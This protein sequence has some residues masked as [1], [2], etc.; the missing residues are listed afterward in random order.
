VTDA[1]LLLGYLDPN[2]FL[3]GSMALD[4]AAA[5]TAVGGLGA[6]LGLSPIETAWAV[7]Q[8]VNESMAGAARVHVIEKAQDPRR[9]ALL[10]FGGGGPVH[11]AGVA[12]A[13]GIGQVLCPPGAGVASAI[14]LLVAPPS[15]E[16]ARSYPVRLDQIDWRALA[17]LYRELEAQAIERLAQVGVARNEITFERA[18]DGRIAGQLHEIGIPLSAD[19]LGDHR[20]GAVEQLVE[21][22]NRRYRELYKHLPS[23]RPIEL[24]S[25]RLT[26]RGPRPPVGLARS[27]NG[28]A[29]HGDVRKGSRPAYFL[30]AF[31]ETAVYARYALVPGIEIAGPAIVEER[32]STTVVPPDMRATVDPFLNLVITPT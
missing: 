20:G 28:P 2:Y 29:S 30:N 8:V 26:A 19:L 22:F 27:A 18:I 1:D 16:L 12:R 15:L 11:A 3:G 17:D 21:T 10:A 13:L 31:V 4:R 6:R 5:E 24:L 23:G 32:E 25:W 9:F 7:H 14:G